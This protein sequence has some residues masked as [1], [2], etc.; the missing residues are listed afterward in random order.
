M[1]LGFRLREGVELPAIAEMDWTKVLERRGTGSDVKLDKEEGERV[2][3][4]D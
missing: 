3:V 2:Q 1:K 4:L